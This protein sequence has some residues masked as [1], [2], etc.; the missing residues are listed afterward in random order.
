MLHFVFAS[1]NTKDENAF[2]SVEELYSVC[3]ETFSVALSSS[4]ELEILL[5]LLGVDDLP[6]S[7]DFSNFIDVSKYKLP[8][9]SESGFDKLYE[10]WLL[11]TGR[12]TNMDEYGQ[13][14]FIQGKAQEWNQRSNRII[15]NEKP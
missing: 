1:P 11:K 8:E 7:E 10:Q 5:S 14:I 13:L 6:N 15:L 3:E 4:K 12:E 9:L 2:D